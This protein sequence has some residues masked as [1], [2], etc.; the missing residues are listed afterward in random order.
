MTVTKILNL[1]KEEERYQENTINLIAS[2]NYPEK[3]ILQTYSNIISNKY[4]EGYPGKRYYSGV[5]FVDEIEAIAIEKAKQLFGAEH[6]NV[7]PHSG[8]QA[9]M[10]VL[11]AVLNSG[12]TILSADL[13]SG[14]HI[15]H[16]NKFS[17]SGKFF[18]IVHYNLDESTNLINYEKI[19]ELARKYKPKLIIVGYSSYPRK[20]DFSKFK[21]IAGEV[22]SYLL[23]DIAHIAGFVCTGLHQNPCS[24][25]DF[26]T[27][28]T[29]KS[30]RGP[31]GG[32]ILCK[33]KYA[34]Q[35][36]RMVFPGIQG[37]SLNNIIAGKAICFE[38]ALKNEFK[39]YI[40]TLVDNSRVFY[41]SL[42]KN[43]FDIVSG[44]S[45]NHI[46]LIDLRNKNIDGHAAQ[47][48][49]EK[50]NILVNKNLIPFDKNSPVKPSGIR[51]GTLGITTRKFS[52]KDIIKVADIISDILNNLKD[53]NKILE[54]RKIVED[55][56][57]KYPIY[58]E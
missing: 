36:D 57:K 15:S 44:G 34:E 53:E 38:L 1:L 31:K 49:L 25:A 16:G 50:A 28:T 46:I 6:A 5:K 21:E 43:K 45:D 29:H 30:L 24:F 22:N 54:K 20:I 9:N 39:K 52:K 42:I 55:I 41:Q 12:D 58:K 26:V 27:L 8:T 14:G 33:N 7:Q 51:I 4:S 17:F 10:A 11:F 48:V 23:C 56:C 32:I 18:N 40:Q 47:E 37:G 19:R 13:G 2:E 35:I 3:I